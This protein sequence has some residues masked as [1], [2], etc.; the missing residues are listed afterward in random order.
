MSSILKIF[1]N[2]L[3]HQFAWTYDWIADLVSIG[4]WKTW[5]NMVLPHLDE[6][7]V[8]ELGCGPGHLQSAYSIKGGVIIG[9]D[10][11]W[12]ML[13]QANRNLSRDNQANNLVYSFAQ[14]LP[15]R[16][17]SFQVVVSTFPSSYIY[18]VQT[19]T[20]VW[21]VLED[22]GQLIILP[23]A[24]ITGT[25]ILD[26]F[27]SWLFTVTGESPDPDR[28]DLES[29]FALPLERLSEAGFHTQY[30]LMEIEGSSVLMVR[31]VKN[32]LGG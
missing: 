24:W 11:S 3:Y 30:E 23:A 2:L 5:V 13:R 15:F 1:F 10:A 22:E 9:L 26:R 21:R 27:A 12:Q 19:L 17:R 25:S 29:M 8:L 14:S 6:S 28:S 18:E 20:Q 16:D 4:R 32:L 31:A 7:K